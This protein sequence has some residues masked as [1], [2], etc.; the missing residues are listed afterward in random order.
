MAVNDQQRVVLDL[1]VGLQDIEVLAEREQSLLALGVLHHLHQ[2]DAG[3]V[4]AGRVQA[5]NDGGG[6]AVLVRQDQHTP[7][8][9]APQVAGARGQRRARRQPGSEVAIG[10]GLAHVG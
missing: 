2:L 9:Q 7:G 3:P 4:G 8:F 1:E 5:R 6:G 10:Q